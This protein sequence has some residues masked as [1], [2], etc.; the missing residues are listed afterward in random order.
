MIDTAQAIQ[1]AAK[2][3][4][5]G[6]KET[7][8]RRLMREMKSV[9]VA[10][11]GGVDSAYLAFIAHQELGSN[12]L[13]VMG[14]SPSVSTYQRVEAEQAAAECGFDLLKIETEEIDDANYA[15]N[16]LNRCYFCKSELYSK[17]DKIAAER[18][19]AFV[20]DGTNADDL[21]GH[22]PGRAAAHQRGVRSPMAEVGLTKAD[23]RVQSK[24]HGL[25]TWDKPASPCL[26]SRIA[27]GLPVTIERLS[28]IE[29]GEQYLRDAGFREFRVRVHGDLV[30]LEIS[31]E[32]IA[33]ALTTEMTGRFAKAFK[34]LGFQYVTLD[35]MGF[36]SG[37]TNGATE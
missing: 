15:A 18:G 19:I 14:L 20:V 11:S 26:A 3:K 4:T 12:S 5:S 23:I 31:P 8:L 27:P 21:S 16:P 29:R 7:N 13:C 24:L 10:Y 37:S 30:R 36:R 6:E 34:D 1:A 28:K 17:L 22:R 25:R 2:T 32:E 9:L 35:L 33:G